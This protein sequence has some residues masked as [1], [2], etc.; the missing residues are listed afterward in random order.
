M[1][2]DF[3]SIYFG[4]ALFWGML[5][6]LAWNEVRTVCV[7]KATDAAGQELVEMPCS[8]TSE[9]G[10]LIFF[11]C[12]LDEA[13]EWTAGDLPGLADM[14]DAVRLKAHLFVSTVEMYQCKETKKTQ[15][16]SFIRGR[17][18]DIPEQ[19]RH[20]TSP[21]LATGPPDFGRPSRI[22]GSLKGAK[23]HGCHG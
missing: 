2:A 4:I 22:H 21:P 13:P 6:M 8:G 10:K 5:A 16:A 17:V 14:S 23:D 20:H 18:G 11:S 19:H 15:W 3:C 1:S 7:E 12:P 9:T